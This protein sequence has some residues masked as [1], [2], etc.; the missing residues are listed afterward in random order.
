MNQNLYVYRAVEMYNGRKPKKHALFNI[1]HLSTFYW[2]GNE[3]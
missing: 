1:Q 3:E 2:L